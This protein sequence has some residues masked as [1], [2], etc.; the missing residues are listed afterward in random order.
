MNEEMFDA[1]LGRV[2]CKECVMVKPLRRIIADYSRSRAEYDRSTAIIKYPLNGNK[3]DFPMYTFNDICN[4]I[5]FSPDVDVQIRGKLS[6]QDVFVPEWSLTIDKPVHWTNEW[7]VGVKRRATPP[8]PSETLNSSATPQKLFISCRSNRI[9]YPCN[10]VGVRFNSQERL[11]TTITVRCNITQNQV[12]F[13]VNGIQ[14]ATI[15]NV[16]NLGSAVPSFT[17]RNFGSK[18]I[19]ATL[20]TPW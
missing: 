19:S 2:F 11:T 12:W 3:R 20:S 17:L 7:V 4:T 14:I 5:T 8:T 18:T 6:F 15:M 10:L 13:F 16:T 9:S 1:V